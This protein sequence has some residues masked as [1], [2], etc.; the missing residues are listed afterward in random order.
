MEEQEP[1]RRRERMRKNPH[2]KRMH[3]E[4]SVAGV[5]LIHLHFEDTERVKQERM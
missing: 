3:I 5:G 4:K 1:R 2:G